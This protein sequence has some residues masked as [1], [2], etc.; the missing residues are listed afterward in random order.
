MQKITISK[1]V[2]LRLFFDAIPDSI[3]V[4]CIAEQP[5]DGFNNDRQ[6]TMQLHISRPFQSSEHGRSVVHFGFSLPVT[7]IMAA[8]EQ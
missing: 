7:P 8:K 6:T 5:I 2:L 4:N 3:E 1:A